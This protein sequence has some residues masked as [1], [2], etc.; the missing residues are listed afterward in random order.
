[1][2]IKSHWK[3]GTERCSY[4]RSNQNFWFRSIL[5]IHTSWPERSNKLSIMGSR[6]FGNHLGSKP[7]CPFLEKTFQMDFFKTTFLNCFIEVQYGADDLKSLTFF[8][9]FQVPKEQEVGHCHLARWQW[10][11]LLVKLSK[12]E[13]FQLKVSNHKQVSSVTGTT[14][15]SPKGNSLICGIGLKK[16]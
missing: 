13:S 15:K 2:P 1:M 7:G 11:S 8:K 12:S 14:K 9:G 16:I 3:S 10:S 6:F 5:I 4:C